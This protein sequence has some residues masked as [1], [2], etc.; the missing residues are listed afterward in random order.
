MT[1]DAFDAA[2]DPRTGLAA[3]PAAGGD[4]TQSGRSGR[5]FDRTR[6]GGGP[7][8][9]A[10][11]GHMLRNLG[12]GN[13]RNPKP[14]PAT[15]YRLDSYGPDGEPRFVMNPGYAPASSAG[16]PA[17]AYGP[18]PANAGASAYGPAPGYGAAPGYGPVVSYGPPPGYGPMAAYGPAPYTAGAYGPAP[19]YPASGVYSAPGYGPPTF[20]VPYI[21]P[22]AN[23]SAEQ[24]GR[25]RSHGRPTG[26]R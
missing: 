22:P 24:L 6:L 26:R 5:F 2:I 17:A 25:C 12:G 11:D 3:A 20:V 18:M 9:F 10:F 13:S 7:G 19:G 4:S 21:M 8:L 16:A 14:T 1:D 23:G 15:P